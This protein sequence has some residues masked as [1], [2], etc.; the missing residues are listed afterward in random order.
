MCYTFG[1]GADR[2]RQ[3]VKNSLYIIIGLFITASGYRLCLIPNNIVSGGFTGIG[4][5]LNRYAN[6]SVGMVTALLNI[7]LFLASMRSMGLPFGLRSLLAMLGLSVLIDCLPFH[8]LTDDMLLA[9][10]YGGV[11]TGVGLGLI[12]R[13]SA[14]TGGTDMLASLFHRVLPVL[15]VSYAIFIIDGLII[16]ASAFVFDAQA[17]MYGLISEF[18][19]NALVDLV[20]EGPDRAHACFIISDRSE[21]IARKIMEELGRGVTGLSAMGMYKR[22]EKQ[23]LLC[24]VNRFQSM[25]LRRVI[26]SVD[27]AAF[28]ISC[29]ANEVLGEGF[30]S[31]M[32]GMTKSDK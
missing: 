21:Q 29:R 20:L 32:P 26:F 22:T 10:V 28:V 4:Q 13:G 3:E 30:S 8:P 17:A 24:V 25:H 23:V 27:P 5:L 7:P 1:K 19:C 16:V 2:V 14:T 31:A 11:I 6:I 9:C 12:L 18:I 15:K